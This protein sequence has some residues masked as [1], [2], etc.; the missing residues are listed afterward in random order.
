MYSLLYGFQTRVF[1]QRRLYVLHKRGE[2]GRHSAAV[3]AAAPA[4]GFSPGIIV[5]V[6][7][8]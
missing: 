7:L 8:Y 2:A 6:L 5:L 4:L 1:S 3:A